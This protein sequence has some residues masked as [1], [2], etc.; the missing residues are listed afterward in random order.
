MHLFHRTLPRPGRRENGDHLAW[1]EEAGLFLGCVADGVGSRPCDGRASKQLCTDFLHSFR[2]AEPTGDLPLRLAGA[3]RSA[4]TRLYT[5]EAPCRGMRSTLT[6]LLLDKRA[7]T[8]HYFGIGDSPLLYFEGE[9]V[10]QLTYPSPFEPRPE[11]IPALIH[12]GGPFAPDSAFALLTDGISDNRP[13]Y[14]AELRLAIRSEQPDDRLEQWVQLHRLTQSDD[15][16][17]LLVWP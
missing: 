2:E 17:M 16:S 15:M 1:L 4:F 7:R 6:G 9:Q 12:S 8:F 3:L 13:G 10:R 11:A 14:A 5:A